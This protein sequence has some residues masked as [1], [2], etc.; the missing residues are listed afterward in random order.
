MVIGQEWLIL[1]FLALI[2][3]FGAK[4][5]PELARALGRAR[6]EFERGKMDIEKELKGESTDKSKPQSKTIDLETREKLVKVAKEL[7][8]DPEGKTN[9]ELRAE[10][11]KKLQ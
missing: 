1:I 2:L 9:D 8:I 7:G 5:I 11:I 4:K 10:I 6:M 3:I